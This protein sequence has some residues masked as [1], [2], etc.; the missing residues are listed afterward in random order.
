MNEIY[1]C[2]PTCAMQ[3][4]SLFILEHYWSL[5]VDVIIYVAP[6]WWTLETLSHPDVWCHGDKSPDDW[7][8]FSVF[9]AMTGIV[10]RRPRVLSPC[11]ATTVGAQSDSYRPKCSAS[12]QGG[13]AFVLM[14]YSCESWQVQCQRSF[15]FIGLHC[16]LQLAF[17]RHSHVQST[18]SN[19]R[20]HDKH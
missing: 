9:I 7:R 5:R 1:S 12:C 2:G 4:E 8:K 3:C 19:E 17:I 15:Q 6:S 13:T 10:H 14:C 18:F 16:H 20:H 11:T